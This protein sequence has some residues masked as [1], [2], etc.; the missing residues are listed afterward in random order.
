VD[1]TIMVGFDRQH[2]IDSI[3]YT[4]PVTS[5]RSAF[6]YQN[7]LWLVAAKLVEKH[8]GK[9]WEE[10]IAERIFKPLGMTS[11][12]CDMNSYVTAADAATL[13]HTMGDKIVILPM[14]WPNLFWVYTYGPAGG[15]NSNIKDVE[16]WARMQAANGLF[17]GRQVIS[18]ENVKFMHTPQTITQ[19]Q[20]PMHYYCLGW[21]YREASPYPIV[22]HNGGT[23]GSKTMIALVP[24]AKLGVIVLSN[25]IDSQLPEA[26][27]YKFIDMYF[28]NPEHD[29]SEEE[30]G[31]AKQALEKAKAEEPKR[32]ESPEAAMPLDKYA[33]DYANDVYG[34]VTVSKKGEGLSLIIGPR[35]EEMAL[36]HWDRD[37]FMANW[38]YYGV[39]EDAGFVTFRPGPD[40]KVMDMVVDAFNN[41]G[42]GIFRK[43]E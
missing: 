41:D 22:W 12:S 42:C 32:P 1:G 43:A 33:G 15:I 28:G 8:T 31:K 2:T 37:A 38:K 13:H 34:T 39:P 21:I 11:S 20:T 7:N 29:W 17:E 27:A 23:S 18:Q 4:K 16:K 30:L 35:K 36:S 3:R 5:F 14:D 9:T 26:L 40:G 24:Q 19:M 6:A 25:L 10:N